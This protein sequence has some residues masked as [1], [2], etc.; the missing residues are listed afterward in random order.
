MMCE[1]LSV[2]C[3]VQSGTL[4]AKF[5]VRF[6]GTEFFGNARAMPSRKPFANHYSPFAVVL[7]RQEPRPPK[8][9][10]PRPTTLVPFLGRRSVFSSSTTG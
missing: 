8:F 6:L 10:V 9:F 1:V 2:G 7:A 5:N 4:K 3:N